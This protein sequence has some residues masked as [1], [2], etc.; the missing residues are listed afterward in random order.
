MIRVSVSV[1]APSP[2]HIRAPQ[3][4]QELELDRV[5]AY[6]PPIVEIWPLYIMH[7]KSQWDGGS[8]GSCLRITRRGVIVESSLLLKISLFL[9]LVPGNKNSRKRNIQLALRQKLR[10]PGVVFRTVC[11]SELGLLL[12]L[13]WRSC[14]LYVEQEWWLDFW[15]FQFPQPGTI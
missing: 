6:F 8:C 5:L 7:S 3:W 12:Q 2:Y 15:R 9:F 14:W 1:S 11:H 4:Y 13:M 10:V